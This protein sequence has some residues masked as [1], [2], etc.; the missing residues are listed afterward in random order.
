MAKFQWNGLAESDASPP[1]E[2]EN[3]WGGTLSEWQVQTDAQS[4]SGGKVLAFTGSSSVRRA[5]R[6]SAA[7]TYEQTNK[8]DVRG[9]IYKAGATSQHFFRVFLAGTAGSERSLYGDIAATGS[10]CRLNQYTGGTYLGIESVGSFPDPGWYRF[11]YTWDPA[12]P[13][14]SLLSLWADGDEEPVTPTISNNDTPVSGTGGSLGYG[15][16]ADEATKLDWITFGVDEPADDLQPSGAAVSFSGPVP[17]LAIT[18][19][20]SSSVD[21]STYFSGTETPFTYSSVGTG[22]PAEFSLDT[23]T[24]ILSWTNAVLGATSGVVVRA[25]DQDLATADSNAFDIVVSAAPTEATVTIAATETGSDT[26]L[27]TA[28]TDVSLS[29]AATETGSDVALIV[30]NVEGQG[31]INLTEPL[32]N[33]TGTPLDLQTGISVAVL[34]ATDLSMIGVQTGLTTDASGILDE[35]SV[36]G[37]VQGSSYILLIKFPDGAIGA[38]A[39]VVAA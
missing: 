2:F 32:K 11:H 6:L 16:F 35:I 9:R 23:A 36:T 22:L 20:A 7:G 12:A 39:A 1:A 34:D 25:T 15:T 4:E 8:I 37:M 13:N 27:I 3:I 14:R 29:I 38:T 10:P 21:L 31:V 5:L 33:N 26:A 30:I 18:E 19:G 28:D 24:G 17:D